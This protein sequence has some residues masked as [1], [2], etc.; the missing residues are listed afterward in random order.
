MKFRDKFMQQPKR[1]HWE[2]A[3]R[4][5]RYIKTNPG[6][7]ILLSNKKSLELEAFCD[8]D[9]A[10]YPNTRRSSAEAEYRSMA[11][12][13]VEVIWLVGV[14]KELNV[15]VATPVKLHCDS[16]AALQIAAN[17]IFHE[18]TKH[19]EIDCHF[20]RERI[21]S[22]M[23]LST[24]VNTNQQ[25]TGILTKGLGAASHHM[26]LSKLGVFNVYSD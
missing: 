21:K 2:A 13:V 1:S 23:I 24:Y 6:Q 4:L 3:M 22:G 8:S 10:A 7:G 18:R 5:V 12:V 26:L 20:V 25:P 19:I 14:L 9:W 17:P 11:G 15:N 16:K